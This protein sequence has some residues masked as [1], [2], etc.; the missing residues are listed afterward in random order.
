V[1]VFQWIVLAFGITSVF[2]GGF[3]FGRMTR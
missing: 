3:V 1:S 2:V